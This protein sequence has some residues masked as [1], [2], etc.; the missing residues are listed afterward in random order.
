MIGLDTQTRKQERRG[1]DGA[2]PMR[3]EI[4]A[5]LAGGSRIARRP[6]AARWNRAPFAMTLGLITVLGAC[7]VGPDFKPPDDPSARG[8]TN[9]DSQQPVVSAGERA[10]HVLIGERSDGRWWADFRSPLLDRIVAD[11][12]SNNRSL[13]VAR[14]NL[15]QARHAIAQA[16]GALYPQVDANAGASRQRLSLASQGLNVPPNQFNLFSLGAT[17]SFA[18]DPFG[19]NRRRVEQQT[20]IAE[21]QD[22]QLAAAWLTLVGNCISQLVI[23]GAAHDQI[24]AVS[25]IIADD[26]RNI[27]LVETEM[28]SGEAT[29]IDLASAR[30]QLSADR[31]LLPPLRQ[32][33]HAAQDAVSLLIGKAASEW[34]LP[35]ISLQDV[36]LPSAVPLSVP[37]QLVHERPDI[38]SAEA[39]LHAQ[40]AAIGVA[41]AQL[42][43]N[44]TLSASLG[45]QALSAA[46][47]FSPMGTIWSLAG[48]AMAPI[49]HGGE[50]EAQRQ[51]AM[52][53]YTAARA[54]YEQTVLQSFQQVADLLHSLANDTDLL[55]EQ[56]RAIEAAALSL[57]LTRTTFAY[58]NV[59]LLQLLDA[60]RQLAHARLGYISASAQRYQDTIQ[61][62]VAMGSGWRDWHAQSGLE[63]AVRTEAPRTV[64]AALRP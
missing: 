38:L 55:V 51:G 35:D 34:Q 27:G 41:T 29:R 45:Q 7:A 16:S 62:F 23:I 12:I 60:Q 48:N 57:D 15:S 40:S 25:E 63:Q 4:P 24:Q 31:A 6:R 61:L 18:L 9:D 54:S 8:Y 59:S 2:R 39:Q 10:Q 44:V 36:A 52:D 47:L 11:A 14:A 64:S 50:L 20:A 1:H 22:Y 33:I 42:Y 46:S 28:R 56:R 5:S 37:S 17:V 49:F 3:D 26:E 32:Q 30:S 43:P 53:A 21:A 13:A 58:G 19:G